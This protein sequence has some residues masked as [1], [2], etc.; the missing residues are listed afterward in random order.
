MSLSE[1]KK[2]LYQK[3]AEENLARHDESEYDARIASGT[4][5]SGEPGDAWEKKKDWFGTEEKK[6]SKVG[7]VALSIVL[8]IIA[9]MVIGYLVMSALFKTE[10]VTVSINGTSEAKSGNLITYEIGYSND[11]FVDIKNATLRLT[12]PA[13]IRP[14]SNPDFVTS[15][16]TTGTFN[17]GTIKSHGS[18]KI[19]FNVRTYNP[20]GALVYLKTD[21]AYTPFSI[22]GQSVASNQLGINI[23]TSP[24]SIEVAAP[25]SVS[26]GDQVDYQIIYKNTSQEES[27]GIRIRLE[28]PDGFAFTGSDPK[29]FEGGN[30]WY[31]GTLAPGQSG[32]IV[33]SGKLEGVQGDNKQVK[34]T[35][36][37]VENSRFISYN[38]EDADTKIASSPFVI[39]QT[40]NG[41]SK[42]SVNA[43]DSLS[44]EINYKNTGTIGLRDAIVKEY[45]DSPVLDYSLLDLK[46][47]GV[48]DDS[49]KTITWKAS[50]FPELANVL[51]GQGG[52]IQFSIRVKET[53][54]IAGNNDKNF[55]ISSLAKIDSPD[56]PTSIN[57][58]KVIAG[59]RMDMRLNS[60]LVLDVKAY[61][62]DPNIPN[63]GP[64]PPKVGQETTYTVHLIASNISNDVEG[65]KVE[66]VLPTGATMTGAIFPQD[67]SLK[68]NERTN[69]LV[70]D[71]GNIPSG[72]GVLTV[73]Q[74]VSFQVRI[75]PS[76][77]QVRKEA[78][79][80]ER[81]AF[82]AKDTFT[83]ENLSVN[84]YQKTTVLT[85]DTSVP[86]S[87]YRVVN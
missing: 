11:N 13:D 84:I 86:S 62:N 42:L 15:E 19:T 80:M 8:G 57:A 40:V 47:K 7:I 69:S 26:S 16:M 63:S 46:G 82:S 37:I 10:R 68:Y 72:T 30:V 65:A 67:A 2:K 70:W 87:A 52:K 39:S 33:A 9:I 61:Y 36:G 20:K 50:D 21:L 27:N 32:K 64:I 77:D 81:A 78:I 17:I 24:I 45:L 55:I 79:L 1:I 4:I 22:G 41:R 44:F 43:K 58:N 66:A 3:N 48:Y 29:V 83:G 85:E 35:V 51:P 12:Y 54:P 18:G 14:E 31:I 23:V 34:A 76:L 53:I 56:V 38:E 73:P 71:M 74:E 75:K 28:Y 59:N 25:Q 60:K 6:A 49:K 5:N